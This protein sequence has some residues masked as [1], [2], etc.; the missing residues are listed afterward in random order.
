MRET[1]GLSSLGFA[2]ASWQAHSLVRSMIGLKRGETKMEDRRISLDALIDR[3][4]DWY[5]SSRDARRDR[6][7][8][9]DEAVFLLGM[10]LAQFLLVREWLKEQEGK[11]ADL[12][13]IRSSEGLPE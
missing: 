4:G 3:L 2:F 13:N 7:R 9:R 8:L 10:S 1:S 12:D 6:E 5:Q 11:V